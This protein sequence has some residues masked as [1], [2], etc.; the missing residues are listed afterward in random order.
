M[1]WRT[2]RAPTPLGPSNLCAP[3]RN[4]IG[5]Q[6]AQVQ[7][8]VRGRLDG[9]DVQEDALAPANDLGDLGHRLDRADLVVGKH[10]RHQD[11]AVR[12]CR[13]ELVRIDPPV[14]IDRELDDLEAELLEVAQ[15]VPHGVVLD[16]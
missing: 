14:P 4:E 16:G 2:Y 5:I 10:D 12:E 15:G 7:I 1:P 13:L 3:K 6:G 9:I 11:R 8:D